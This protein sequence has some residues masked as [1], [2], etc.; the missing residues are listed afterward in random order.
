MSRRE[1]A[2]AAGA[3]ATLLLAAWVSGAGPIAALTEPALSPPPD[4]EFGELVEKDQA[5]N[6]TGGADQRRVEDTDLIA[7]VVAWTIKI[8]LVLVA[9]LIVALVVRALVRLLRGD[10]LTAKDE[11]QA[12]I[13]PDVL[14]AGVRESEARLDAGTSNDAIIAAWLTLER[15]AAAVGLDDDAA[16]TPAELVTSVLE[17]WT[18]DRDAITELAA[19]YREARFSAHPMTEEHRGAARAALRRVRDDLTRPLTELGATS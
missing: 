10:P 8:A 6:R 13:L 3:G 14:L 19:L 5:D 1:W 17:Q 2:W 18:V 7:A 12:P 16:R 11:V 4:K 15:T 9:L